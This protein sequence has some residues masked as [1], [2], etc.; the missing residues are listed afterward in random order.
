MTVQ[1]FSETAIN[2]NGGNAVPQTTVILAKVPVGKLLVVEHISGRL[3]VRDGVE[4]DYLYAAAQG[5]NAVVSLPVQFVSS[6]SQFSDTQGMGRWHQFG[7]A[8][9]L[10]VS[11]GNSVVVS[12]GADATFQLFA[13]AVGY[14]VDA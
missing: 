9:R 14:L 10:Y 13:S 3:A 12:G 8:A 1:P 7:S 11:A 2:D 6:V 4:L 5:A